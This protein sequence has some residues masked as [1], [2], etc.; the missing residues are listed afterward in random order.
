MLINISNSHNSFVKQVIS[1][2]SCSLFITQHN[3]FNNK[4]FTS[5]IRPLLDLHQLLQDM[6]LHLLL[7][8]ML[9][10]Q[11]LQ[12]MLQHLLQLQLYHILTIMR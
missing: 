4:Q 11:L 2:I 5:N 3:L 1:N 7:Q 6:H 8:D 9:L 10:H 12:D